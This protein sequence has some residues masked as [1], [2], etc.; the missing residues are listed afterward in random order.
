MNA[1]V[2]M[3]ALA[4]REHWC[5][6]LVCTTCGHGVFRWGLHAL[7]QGKVPDDRDWVVHW[8]PQTTFS[9]LERECG[10]LPRGPWPIGEQQILQRLTED[11]NLDELESCVTFPD[12]LGHLGVLLRYTEDAERG[13]PTL[14]GHLVDQLQHRVSPESP[15]EELLVSIK[16]S[17]RPLRWT[18]LEILEHSYSRQALG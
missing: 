4:A 11:L 7:A 3:C 6:N 14:T 17:G 8:S 16:K 10:P 5:W 15:A 18:D 13:K 2:Q 1:F 9:D 12:W